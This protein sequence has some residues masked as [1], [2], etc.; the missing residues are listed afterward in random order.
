MPSCLT[1]LPDAHTVFA[2]DE[3]THQWRF[4]GASYIG[5]LLNRRPGLKGSGFQA[6]HIIFKDLR[7]GWEAAPFQN[8][9]PREFFRKLHSAHDPVT[10]RYRL[11]SFRFGPALSWDVGVGVFPEGISRF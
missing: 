3:A 10:E 1:V 5:R 11:V 6:A 9:K 8:S 4:F 7:H 2:V